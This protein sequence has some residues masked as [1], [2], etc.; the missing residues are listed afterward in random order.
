MAAAVT[1]LNMKIEACHAEMMQHRAAYMEKQEQL[2]LLVARRDDLCD[3][4]AAEAAALEAYTAARE[5]TAAASA[6]VSLPRMRATGR[7]L[8]ELKSVLEPGTQVY[9]TSHGDWM[10]ATFSWDDE[11]TP[12]F[13]N[14]HGINFFSPAALSKAFANRYTHAHPAPTTAVNGWEYI[15]VA[16]GPHEGKSIG[17]VVDEYRATH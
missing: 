14:E 8:G 3:R 1:Q 6:V 17:R 11:G 13:M 12:R 10:S 5:A 7:S 4:A 9:M 2:G 16:H 15:F